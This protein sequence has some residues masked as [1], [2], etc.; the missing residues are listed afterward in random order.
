MKD[1]EFILS[2]LVILSMLYRLLSILKK[3]VI[4]KGKYFLVLI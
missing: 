3:K 2:I 1:I 4:L